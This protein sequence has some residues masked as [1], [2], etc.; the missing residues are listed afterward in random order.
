MKQD[1]QIGQVYQH[2]KHDPANGKWHEYRVIEIVSPSDGL[3]AISTHFFLQPCSYTHTE[4]GEH[5][6]LIGCRDKIYSSPPVDRL[7]VAYVNTKNEDERWIRP[8][9]TFIDGR[10]TPV[11]NEN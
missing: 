11:E 6:D 10:F 8:L 9:E 5:Y 1:L 3:G 2:R 4:N 7:H